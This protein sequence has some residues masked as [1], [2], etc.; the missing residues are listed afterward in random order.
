MGVLFNHHEAGIEDAQLATDIIGGIRFGT[1][2]SCLSGVNHATTRCHDVYFTWGEHDSNI[3]VAS[4]SIAPHILIVGSFLS[5]FTNV[6]EKERARLA[7][8]VMRNRGV[9]YVIALFDTSHPTPKYL[10]YF[11]DWL[12]R[13]PQLGLVIKP[14]SP[15]EEVIE[16]N[17]LVEP[18]R[19][20]VSTGRIFAMADTAPPGDAGEIADYAVGVAGISAVVTA[21]LRGAKILF[22]DYE[23]LSKSVQ[24]PFDVLHS[25]GEKRCVFYDELS[26]EQAVVEQN[27]NPQLN[28]CLGDVS[29]ILNKIDPFRDG[30]ASSRIGEYVKWYLTVKDSGL[31]R[32]ESLEIATQKYSEK[33]GADKVVSKW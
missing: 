28:I 25:L 8:D 1:H 23:G 15:I 3:V 10:K 13:D 22:L 2:W 27:I 33:W 19:R 24:E 18:Y 9:E 30:L 12:F 11:L 29:P 16:K 17:H 5:E 7:V 20:A 31:C 32:E 21:A 26:L 4:K 14:K 6:V